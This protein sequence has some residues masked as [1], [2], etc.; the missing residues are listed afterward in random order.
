[1]KKIEYFM[2]HGSPWTFLGHKRINKIA[3]ENNYELIIMP[4]NYGEFF[5]PRE[6]CRLTRGLSKGKSIDFRNWLDGLNS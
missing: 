6:V 4:V 5:Q 3:L 1:M 2:S